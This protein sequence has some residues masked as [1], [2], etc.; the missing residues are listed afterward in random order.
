MRRNQKLIVHLMSIFLG[1]L[2]IVSILLVIVGAIE[3]SNAYTVMFEAQLQTASEHIASQFTYE[4]EGDW[5]ISESGELG[6]GEIIVGDQIL[7]LSKDLKAKT[8]LDYTICYETTRMVSTLSG[9]EGTKV[10]DIVAQTVYQQKEEYLDDNVIINGERYFA[11][12]TPMY[13]DDGSIAGMIAANRKAN[14]LT[15]AVNKAIIIMV[16]IA[17]IFVAIVLGIGI[18]ISLSTTKVMTNIVDS[19]KTLS[20]GKLSI[21]IDP[22]A[23]ARKDELGTIAQS[24]KNLDDELCDVIRVTKGLSNDVTKSGDELSSSSEQASQAS[25]Q[26]TIAVDEISRGAV[27]QAESIQSSAGNTNDIGF[28]IDSISDNIEELTEYT[29]NMKAACNNAMQ[30]LNQVLD[31]NATVIDQ[32]REID[33]QIKSTNEAVQDIS[34]ASDIITSISSQTNLL[35]LNASIE[36]ARA[37]D[38]GKGFAVVATE[39]GQLAE[40]SRVAA[41]KINKIV[42]NLVVESQKSVDTLDELNKGIEEQNRQLD[43]TR[44]DMDTMVVDVDN[45][46]TSSASISERINTL[47]GSKN[48]LIDIIQDLSAISEEN[49]ASTE[50]TNASMEELNATFDVISNSA[51]EL[52]NLAKQLD[53][54]INFFHFD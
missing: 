27:S 6:K 49:A 26:V 37:G 23:L 45:V 52:K 20:E 9:A 14:V 4:W 32:M 41:V 44:T 51:H 10:D 50:E 21:H 28:D 19:L 29:N 3:V 24:T 8:E 39:I 47:N 13:N 2:V 42:E 30:A 17:I 5:F 36:A 46:A 22:S 34:E 12:Y 35:S 1:A 53:E 11:Y 18:S 43:S 48:S 33:E 54:K 15:S 31:Q 38:A 16:V 25:G 7:T 40:Q